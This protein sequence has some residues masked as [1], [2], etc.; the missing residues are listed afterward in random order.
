MFKKSS[1]SAIQKLL[2]S[3]PKI[4]IIVHKNP[5]GDAVGSA[6]GWQHVLAQ[7]GFKSDVVVPDAFPKYLAFLPG[8][9]E[10]TVYDESADKAKS[11]FSQ[12]DLIF[13][14]DF[15]AV[16]RMGAAGE[17]VVGANKPIVLI[18]HHQ[19]PTDFAHAYYTDDTASST[20]ELICRLVKALGWK[21]HLERRGAL[22]LYTGIITDTGSFR[23]SSVSPKLMRIASRLLDTGMD[24]TEVYRNI[25]DN[26]T[27]NRLRL[28]GFALTEK[29]TVVDGAG[30]A[31][32]AL[33]KEELERFHFQKGDTEGFVNYALSIQGVEVAAF[34]SEAKDYVKIS[35]RSRRDVDVNA[36]ARA[37]FQGGGHI[38]AAGGRSDRNLIET[39]AYF[40]DICRK[41]LPVQHV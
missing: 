16:E 32:I 5:D 7:A 25:F 11:I 27:L 33:S 4:A 36:M 18:D 28:Q 9:A 8:S 6:L 17:A 39:A 14:L 24:H 37:H 38:N 19:S 2:A 22:C 12:S 40:E 35:L 3:K 10:I 29:L 26:N 23:F 41:L 13:C 30:A 1:V 31:Y 21:Q 20:C 15:N 34:F